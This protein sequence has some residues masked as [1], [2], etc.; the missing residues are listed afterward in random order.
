MT[1]MGTK[2]IHN[3]DTDFY[4]NAVEHS[5]LNVSYH[6]AESQVLI[7]TI[8]LFRGKGEKYKLQLE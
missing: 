3:T 4:V 8:P 5:K 7:R 2:R 6:V 1:K